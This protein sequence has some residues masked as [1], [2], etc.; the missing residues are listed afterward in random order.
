VPLFESRPLAAAVVAKQC[1]MSED[2][3]Q[4]FHIT[5][6]VVLPECSPW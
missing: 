5:V 1:P 2:C 6:D 4:F 3:C